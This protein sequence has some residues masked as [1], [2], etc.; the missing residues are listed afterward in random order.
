MKSPPQP[1]M[2]LLPLREI[3]SGFPNIVEFLITPMYMD[4]KKFHK[5]SKAAISSLC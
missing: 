4:I 2:L 1:S 5:K 3:Y